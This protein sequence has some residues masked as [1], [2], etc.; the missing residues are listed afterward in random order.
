MNFEN[1]TVIVTGAGRG[2][3]KEIARAYAAEGAQVI[4]AELDKEQGERTAEDI[5]R[6]GG[7]ALFIYCDVSREEDIISL[8]DQTVQAF[9]TIDILINNAGYSQRSFGEI[10]RAVRCGMG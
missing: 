2:I 7:K 3:G 8:A 9:G 1:L 10:L 5:R 4:I 6:E